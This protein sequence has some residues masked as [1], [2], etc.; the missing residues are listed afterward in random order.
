MDTR[1]L[2]ERV[3]A[4]AEVR[5]RAL[6]V[7]ALLRRLDAEVRSE[8]RSEQLPVA[9]PARSCPS[10]GQPLLPGEE[11]CPACPFVLP[12]VPRGEYER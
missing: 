1:R 6:R 12:Y 3:R 8:R 10:C 5:D 11:R 9:P 4:L 2:E 7:A